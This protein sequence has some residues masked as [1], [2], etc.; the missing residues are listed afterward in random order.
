M[1]YEIAASNPD[2]G[3]FKQ[4]NFYTSLHFASMFV[5]SGIMLVETLRSLNEE[6]GN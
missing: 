2:L 3:R 6:D 4:N 5:L 1:S